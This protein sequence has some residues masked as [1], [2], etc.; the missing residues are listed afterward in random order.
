MLSLLTII[1][2]LSF[3][4]SDI[5]SVGPNLYPLRIVAPILLLY[6]SILL[7]Q[8][9]IV[10]KVDLKIP[11]ASSLTLCFFVFMALSTFGVSAYRYVFLSQTY[12]PNDLL[13]YLF[14]TVLVVVLFVVGIQDK[15]SFLKK[16]NG[17]ILVFYLLYLLMALYE[18][19]TGFHFPN[20]AL[21]DASDWMKYSPTVVYFNSNDFAAIFTMML[22]YLLLNRKSE[23]E[24]G[25]YRAIWLLV[26][27]LL[28]TYI[29]YKSESR[30]SLL[31]FGMFLMF[32][33]PRQLIIV[34]LFS[35][36]TFIVVGWFGET[37]WFMQGLDEF[38]KFQQDFSFEERNSTLVRLYLYKY[39]L[40]SVFDSYGFGFG[41][42]ASEK[43]YQSIADPNLFY[44]TNPHSYIFEI[45][46]NS[47]LFSF[48]FYILLNIYL[49][50]KSWVY[51]NNHLLLQLILYNLLLFSSSSSLFL[52]PI[53][54]FFV[55]YVFECD[56]IME[57]SQTLT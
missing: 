17:V 4:L 44:I 19:R 11:A 43:Y 24:K 47:G 33:Y 48:I 6:A 39:A 14:V 10:K 42:Y 2:L 41:V 9:S 32:N 23:A 36:I 20:S 29:L 34:C 57:D 51:R 55:L 25:F 18:I 28:H 35:I 38:S 1:L 5:V 46:I 31:V 15:K 45:L 3:F 22:M 40:L 12:E 30:L 54:L 49:M 13:N 56:I 53:Y 8:K 37:S 52:W 50:V 16:A 27:I 26:I 7:F 21:Y